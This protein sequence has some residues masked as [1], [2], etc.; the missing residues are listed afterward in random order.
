MATDDSV[1]GSWHTAHA[2]DVDAHF[3]RQEVWPTFSPQKLHLTIFHQTFSTSLFCHHRGGGRKI[4]VAALYATQVCVACAS[5]E[6][7]CPFNWS[8]LLAPSA[9]LPGA[10][11]DSFI[12]YTP[13]AGF[14]NRAEFSSFSL[15]GCEG[16][17]GTRHIPRRRVWSGLRARMTTHGWLPLRWLHVRAVRSQE[18]AL[19]LGTTSV[20][21]ELLLNTSRKGA[22]LPFCSSFSL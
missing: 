12:D 19:F 11:T 15:T 18:D 21:C 10:R 17:A 22:P 20:I 4:R 2:P 8:G 1:L 6:T 14:E 13:T 7:Y 5:W 3:L 16:R 9:P